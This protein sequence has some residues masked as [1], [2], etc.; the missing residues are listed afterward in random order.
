ML[1][2]W[3]HSARTPECDAMMGAFDSA[4]VCSIDA[5]DGCDTSIIIPSRFISAITWRP[6]G[7]RPL[8]SHTPSRSPVLESLSWLC[9]LWASDR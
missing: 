5:F 7:D 4:T 1:R 8:C 6:S 3:L 2:L 9:P